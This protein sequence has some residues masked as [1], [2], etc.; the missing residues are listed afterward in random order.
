MES[1][2]L[3]I[4]I[5]SLKYRDWSIVP[6]SLSIASLVLASLLILSVGSFWS[7]M[8]GPL[9]RW[10]LHFSIQ[11]SLLRMTVVRPLSAGRIVIPVS[12]FRD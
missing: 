8:K 2:C 10:S 4:C 11:S 9:S 3:R 5:F 1:R 7:L 6:L 12:S